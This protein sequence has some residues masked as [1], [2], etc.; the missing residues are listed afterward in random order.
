MNN[1]AKPISDVP[2]TILKTLYKLRLY[3]DVNVPYKEYIK[4]YKLIAIGNKA[5]HSPDCE[6]CRLKAFLSEYANSSK[7][8][9]LPDA[10]IDGWYITKNRFGHSSFP[11]F[12]PLEM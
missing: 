3:E 11:F 8:T 7:R 10:V 5:F 9:T 4:R 6:E 1:Y 12:N 2:E